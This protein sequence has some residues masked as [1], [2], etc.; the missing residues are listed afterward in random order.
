MLFSSIGKIKCEYAAELAASLSFYFLKSGD[1]VGIVLFNDKIVKY[2]PPNLG[3]NQFFLI[4][5]ILSN[6][7]FYGGNFNLSNAIS[8]TN[9]L[10]RQGAVV[11]IISDFIGLEE[12]W[13]VSIQI[14]SNKADIIGIIIRDPQ[15]MRLKDKIGQTI[16]SDPLSDKIMLV[17]LEKIRA[18]YEHTA[19][20]RLEQIKNIF[21]KNKS[22]S[23]E[24]ETDKPF[25]DPIIKFFSERR[26]RWQ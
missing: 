18:D 7:N 12:K 4:T 11:I 15:D 21:R 24:L 1:N 20:L 2:L 22:E 25:V 19:R 17:D 23:I 14:L 10:A 5:K 9:N 16:I 13:D 3:S 8:Y 26:T 6:P